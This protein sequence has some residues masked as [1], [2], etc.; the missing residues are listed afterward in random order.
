MFSMV[1]CCL[2]KC[3]TLREVSVG[4]LGLS[5][6][7]ETVRI[8]HFPKKSTLADTSK[9]RKVKFFEEIYSN[10][11]KKYSFVLSNSRIEIALGKKVK[12]VDSTTIC[13]FKDILECVRL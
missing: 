10:L 8:N 4:I 3:N 9:G 7:E 5:G 12:I 2:E 6:K 11:L 13:L 1:F